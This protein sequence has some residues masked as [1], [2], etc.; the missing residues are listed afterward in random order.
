MKN[1][2]QGSSLFW[3][4]VGIGIAA[5]SIKYGVGDFLSPGAG[6]ITFFAGALLSLL[7]A[8][9][10]IKSLRSREPRKSLGSLWAGL[11]FGKVIYVLV[12]LILYALTLRFLG[13]VPT[14]FVLLAFLF[15]V[16]GTFSLPKVLSLSLLISLGAYL[17]FQVWL[18]VQLPKGILEG[19]I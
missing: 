2:D 8:V 13:F 6:F 16:K 17:V 3:L 14:T 4:A 7:S 19:I 1:P 11:S 9:L 15:R 5:G 18:Q 10:F 12:L